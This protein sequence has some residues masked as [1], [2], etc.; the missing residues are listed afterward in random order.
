MEDVEEASELLEVSDLGKKAVLGELGEQLAS[1]TRDSIVTLS[2]A[3]FLRDIR[4]NAT[5]QTEAVNEI[6]SAAD[7]VADVTLLVLKTL[8]GSLNLLELC[9][10][11]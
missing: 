2:K 5:L 3:E 6:L 9:N 11:C 4:E 8:Q 7:E 1:E 10:N